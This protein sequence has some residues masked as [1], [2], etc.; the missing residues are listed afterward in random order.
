MGAGSRAVGGHGAALF[1]WP[2]G[3]GV[4]VRWSRARGWSTVSAASTDAGTT[5]MCADDRSLQLVEVSVPPSPQAA[6]RSTFRAIGV[7]RQGWS[8]PLP[9][10]SD[11]GDGVSCAD[12]WLVVASRRSN[13]ATVIGI[14]DGH[15]G[16]SI[17]GGAPAPTGVDPAID[18]VAAGAWL[19]RQL[20]HAALPGSDDYPV[21]HLVG[22]LPDGS[23]LPMRGLDGI[24]ADDAAWFTDV[25]TGLVSGSL[26]R[27]RVLQW[28]TAPTVLR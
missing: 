10:T 21:E 9:I 6:A 12:G 2:A 4:V 14:A 20:T 17:H 16:G 22:R 13:S 28:W 23:L 3:G 7:G 1:G 27:G 5:A 18:A 24:R 19:V 25:G 15:V 26:E 11:V 8:A